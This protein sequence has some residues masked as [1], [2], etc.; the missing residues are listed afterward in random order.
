[1]ANA[2]LLPMLRGLWVSMTSGKKVICG[3]ASHH[4]HDL[5]L[6]K[7]LIESGQIKTV[8]DK[9]YPLEKIVEAHE[10]VDEGHKRGNVVITLGTTVT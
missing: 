4:S 6:L 7:T 8:I 9:V 1:M 5:H 2:G 10:Y 3:A